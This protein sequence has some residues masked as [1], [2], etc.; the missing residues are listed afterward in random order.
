ML[1]KYE[2]RQTVNQASMEAMDKAILVAVKLCKFYHLSSSH[3]NNSVYKV[4]YILYFKILKHYNI[5]VSIH[6]V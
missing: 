5:H 3:I 1:D 2:Y 4:I 6:N